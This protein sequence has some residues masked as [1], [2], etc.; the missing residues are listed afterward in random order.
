MLEIVTSEALI[1]RE[2]EGVMHLDGN[3]IHTDKDICVKII[4]QGLKILIPEEVEK[5]K[6]DPQSFL[7][8]ITR[9]I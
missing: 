7:T 4:R 1:E 2:S 9:W 3:A 8:N 5:P 6:F